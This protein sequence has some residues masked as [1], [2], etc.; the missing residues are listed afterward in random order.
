MDG[1][2]LASEPVDLDPQDIA[3]IEVVKGAAAASLYGSR[4]QN[5]IINITTKRG[6]R[7]GLGDTQVQF[8]SEVGINQLHNAVKTNQSHW[9]R[10]NSN[11]EWLD[12]DG[13]VVDFDAAADG[14]AA[15]EEK[16]ISD[17]RM[18]VKIRTQ[19][20]R[21]GMDEFTVH[22]LNYIAELQGV[23]Q[24]SN[25]NWTNIE[26]TPERE[27]F[28]AQIFDDYETEFEAGVMEY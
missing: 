8:R 10:T 2:I 11:G 19:K 25:G 24:G 20:I 16:G 23:T 15:E 21:R 27:E 5:G 1:A 26:I 14:V 6:D 17:V 4:A 3:N 22:N 18:K 7:G 13:N 28:M 12:A 9:F